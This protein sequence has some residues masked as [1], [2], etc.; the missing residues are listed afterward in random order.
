M[1][2]EKQ[3]NAHLKKIEIMMKRAQENNAG[4]DS[5]IADGTVQ[6]YTDMNKATM[7]R[8]FKNFGISRIQDLKPEHVQSIVQQKIN[9]GNSANNIRQTVHAM[10]YLQDN[11]L[12][13]GFFKEKHGINMVNHDANLK[14]LKDQKIIRRAEDS[15]RYKAERMEALWVVEEMEKR[16]K[17]F[18]DIGKTQLLL[19]GRVTETARLKAENIDLDGNRVLFKDAKGG[20]DNVVHI[21]HLSG[22]EKAFLKDLKDNAKDGLLFRPRDKLGNYLDKKQVRLGVTELANNCAKKMGVGTEEKTFSSHSFRGAFAHDRGDIYAQNHAHLSRIVDE[23]IKEQPRLKKR[24][25]EFIAFDQQVR[26][27]VTASTFSAAC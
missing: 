14:M 13:T 26:I 25:E 5:G 6:T 3:L 19:G 7:R 27:S 17:V 4:T 9:N 22:D 21:N 11:V 12:T 2:S 18:A 15:H 10:K 20:L 24:Y 1:G 23:K 16:N 8:A